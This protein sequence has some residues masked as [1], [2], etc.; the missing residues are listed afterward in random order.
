M[1][2]IIVQVEEPVNARAMG[3]KSSVV[4]R[5]Q[6][7]QL[8]GMLKEKLLKNIEKMKAKERAK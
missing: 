7:L 8:S 3:R 4:D 2:A 6:G 1:K 5:I